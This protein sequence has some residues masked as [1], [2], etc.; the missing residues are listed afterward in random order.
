MSIETAGM[1]RQAAELIEQAYQ[2]G[3]K[4]GQENALTVD[5][6][7][8]REQGRNEAWEL[9]YR[10]VFNQGNI[11]DVFDVEALGRIFETYSATEAIEKIREY[12]ERQKEDNK[13]KVGDEVELNEVKVIV[14]KIMDNY[15]NAIGYAGEVFS[16]RELRLWKKT[17][18]HYD[19]DKILR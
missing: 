9:A 18:I 14:T 3:Y 2:R 15:F 4:S 17:G 6:D 7:K 13:I 10:L 12:E 19:L 5:S 8:F 1:K 11:R 16:G